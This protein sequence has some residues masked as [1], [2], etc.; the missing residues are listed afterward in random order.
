MNCQI[1]NNEVTWRH[2]ETPISVS[3]NNLD[4]ALFSADHNAVVVLSGPSQTSKKVIIFDLGGT[5]RCEI[6]QPK[7]VY[8]HGLGPNRG[9]DVAIFST[10][11][12]IGWKN[13]WFAIDSNSKDVVS[14]GEGR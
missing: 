11:Y 5:V 3:V 8:F 14:L 7:E 10:T 2:N 1:K 13:W 9:H 6:E 4:Q 12:N